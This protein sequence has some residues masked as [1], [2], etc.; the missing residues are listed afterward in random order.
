MEA[1]MRYRFVLVIAILGAASP[2]AAAFAQSSIDQR[3]Q[4]AFGICAACHSLE[5]NRNMTGPS[6]A[7][8]WNRQAGSLQSFDRYSDALKSSKVIW[9]DKSL[10]DW[11]KNPQRFI[12]GNH[13]TFAGIND[14]RAR[15]DL[16]AFLKEATQPGQAPQLAQRPAGMMGMMGGGRDPNL[17]TLDAEGRVQSIRYCRDTYRVTTADGKTHDFWERNLR[18]KTDS[19]NDGSHKGAPALVGA[20]ML[21]DRADVIFADPSEI[22]RLITDQC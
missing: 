16:L 21:G 15:A 10:D 18:F 8:L 11:L 17:K 13:M 12:P 19:G 7:N 20:G 22:S 14:A 5:P 1:D 4:R 6:L 3:G 2:N 9:D